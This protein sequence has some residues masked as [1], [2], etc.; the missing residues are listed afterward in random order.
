M[1]LFSWIIE[2]FSF[3]KKLI[4]SCLLFIFF[5]G[6]LSSQIITFDAWQKFSDQALMP[7]QVH[8]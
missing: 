8:F 3:F 4:L 7:K 2:H 5:I 1:N 6:S